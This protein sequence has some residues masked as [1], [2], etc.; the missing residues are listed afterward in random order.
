[1]TVSNTEKQPEPLVSLLLLTVVPAGALLLVFAGAKQLFTAERLWLAMIVLALFVGPVTAIYLPGLKVKVVLGDVV[2]FIC[3][4]LFGG[5][6]AVLVAAVDGIS[7]SLRLTKSARKLAYNVATVVIAAAGASVTATA[8]FPLFG[9]ATN[10]LRA[11]EIVAAMGLFAFVYFILSTSLIAAHVAASS[12]KPFLSFWRE[13]FLWTAISF[14]ASGASASAVSILVGR[15]GVYAFLLPV[16]LMTLVFYFYR[17]YFQKVEVANQRAADIEE[18]LRQSQKMEAV[19][20]LAGGVAHDFNNLLTGI[21]GYSDLL[22]H[23]LDAQDPRRRHAEEVKKASERAASL[24]RQLLA[25]SRKQVLQPK[26]IDLNSVLADTQSMLRRLIGEDIDLV[27]LPGP[28]LGAVLADPAQIQQVIMNLAVN[29]RDAMP[30]GGR[31]VIRTANVDLDQPVTEGGVSLQ[32]GRYIMLGVTDS[33]GGM[34]SETQ[35]HIFEPFFTTKVSGKGTGLGLSTVYGIVSQSGGA[36]GVDSELEKGTTFR[37]FLP[38]LEASVDAGAGSVSAASL[39]PAFETILLVEDEDAVRTLAREVLQAQG[40]SVMCAASGSQAM[41]VSE[42]HEGRIDLLVTDV[43]MPQMSGRELAERLAPVRPEMKVLY[44]SG[45]TADV[46]VHLDVSEGAPFLQKP[47]SPYDLA[48]KT[49]E[50]LVAG[51]GPSE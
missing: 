40:Y 30:G 5:P 32:P 8:A 38:R 41:A 10:Q 11:I 23:S 33:G 45:Y 7:T 48:R 2:T 21:I 43:V 35:S 20:R 6:A 9:R 29:A 27:T 51:R 50:V 49:R 44:M 15:F 26:V 3:A 28:L 4:A 14:A 19:G 31:L 13:N 36:I 42:R 22:V 18:Q 37:V 25:F 12:R 24:T 1:M 16:G 39:P 46:L 47:F 34:D 17:T